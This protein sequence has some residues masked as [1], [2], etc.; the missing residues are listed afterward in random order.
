MHLQY[1]LTGPPTAE[2]LVVP[3]L[4]LSRAAYDMMLCYARA[5]GTTEV[6]GFAYIRLEDGV[7]VV[8]T[9]DDVFITR[10]RVTPHT[11]DVHENTFAQA[12]YQAAKQGRSDDLRL[13]WHVHP[14]K[15]YHSAT[16]MASIMA[17][18]HAGMQWFIS[19]VL[20]R[21]GRICARYD[22]FRPVHIGAEME[23]TLYDTPDPVSVARARADIDALVTVVPPPRRRRTRRLGRL[24]V[25]QTG[26]L[27]KEGRK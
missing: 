17:F 2:N 14:D 5:A 23:I 22:I 6:S 12:V 3:R 25:T 27:G 4:A 24:A 1:A 10:Q 19:V 20:N 18:K 26:T 8:T 13:Q 7:F 16:D 11:A 21:E 15:V 9:A